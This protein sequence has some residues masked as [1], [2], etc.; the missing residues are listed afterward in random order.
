[1]N[2]K[3]FQGM[4]IEMKGAVSRIEQSLINHTETH[5]VIIKDLNDHENAIKGTPGNLGL[6]TRLELMESVFKRWERITM[7]AVVAIIGIII[8]SIIGK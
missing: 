7:G 2:D 4:L 8:E 5:R 3:E 6:E 1:M